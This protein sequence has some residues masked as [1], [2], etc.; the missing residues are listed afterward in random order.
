MHFAKHMRRHAHK[1]VEPVA[2][3]SLPPATA[4]VPFMAHND[5]MKKLADA[6]SA[7][8]LVAQAA[9]A[10]AAQAAQQAAVVATQAAQAA[11]APAPAKAV[12]GFYY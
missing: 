6:A 5:A 3:G 2:A 12:A 1:P 10:Q 11:A 4:V 7:K 8:Y 9:A